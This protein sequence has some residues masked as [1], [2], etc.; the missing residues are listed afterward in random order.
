MVR[1]AQLL[2]NTGSPWNASKESSPC[3]WKGVRCSSDNSSVVQLS[4]SGFGISSSD[5]LL[6]I[7][8]VKSLQS[9]DLSNN[10]LSSIPDKFISDCGNIDGLKLLNFSKNSLVGVLPTFHG[11]VGLES[12]DLS[13]NSLSGNISLQLDG[14]VSLKSLNLCSN[15]FS[16]SV[17]VKLG[18]SMVL[19]QLVLSTNFLQSS[20]PPE[21]G[22]YQNLNLIDLSVNK[23][24]GSI[25]DTVGNLTK[26]ETFI[27]SLNNLTGIIPPS[28][29]S[30]RTLKRFAANQNQF[31]GTIP[32]GITSFVRILDL[33]YNKLR[34]SIPSD[35]LSHKQLLYVDLSYN[36]LDGPIP[37]DLSPSLFRLRLG[38][39]R[40]N[41][42]IPSSFATLKGLTYLELDNNSLT[43][44]I[45]G[46]LGSCQS[47]ALLNLAQNQLTG[48][49]PPALGN[50]TNLEVLKLQL[51]KLDGEIPEEIMKL[52]KL[53]ILN[54]SSNSLVGL[55]PSSFSNLQSLTRLNLQGNSLNGSIPNS[56]SR[57]NSLIDLQLGQNQLGG[58]IPQMPLKLLIALNLS[59]NLFEGTI[60]TTL[61]QLT[62]LEVL[63]LSNNKFLGE[64][65]SFLTE[66]YSLSQL[67]VS[68]NQLTGVIPEFRPYV[69]LQYSGGNLGL[70]NKTQG[71]SQGSPKK[72]NSVALAVIPAVVSAVLAVGIVT[73]L[74]FSFSR[75]FLKVDDQQSQPGED[76]PWPRIIE[77]NLLTSNAIHR[78]NIDFDKAMEIVADPINSELK[79]RFS[80]YYKTTMPYGANYFVKKL[81]W[82][83]KIYQSGNHDKF[84]QELE[85][86]GK[87]SN[88][89]VMTPLAYV[90]TVDSAYLFYEYAKKGT[91]FDVL[92]GKLGNDFD[93]ASRY[94]IAVGVA[95]ALT[96]LHGC[97]SGPILLLDLSSRNIFLK[98]LKEPVVGDIELYKVID[99]TK[100][101]GSLSTVAGS[102]GYIAPEYAYT[103][104]I[105]MAGNVYSFGIILLELLTGKPAVSEG[106]ELAKWVV[107]K[108]K[109]QDKLDHILDFNISRS[110][111][112]VRGQMLAVLQIALSCVSLSPVARPKMKSVLR[113]ILNAR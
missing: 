42:T 83:D 26:L 57:L 38:S 20:I 16:G 91:L 67:I 95:Q 35:L 75:R 18:N 106:T 55:I 59:S 64:I 1:V 80:T 66:L 98:S 108:A 71:T 107:N 19:E 29:V 24:F 48:F 85:V 25:P 87:L 88:S 112:S 49:L 86:I 22:N 74:V 9:L 82:S 79:T 70:V 102:V 50:L 34:G 4:L 100:S 65:P 78:S 15:K 113:M 21:I 14:L 51:N 111:A 12:L 99:P 63:D 69:T 2:N 37:A 60:P 94:S 61:S 3:S 52:S 45:P 8:E 31:D 103:M 68:N 10:Y 109:Q 30:I 7:C 11:F 40:L 5:F 28:L 41:G 33:S 46:E 13:F 90:L 81:N 105:T 92:H 17:P 44:G 54:I 36:L 84:G 97:A 101:T 47:L 56:I 62:N 73:I 93:W 43:S 58:S 6:A 89:N 27:L 110:S 23:L 96:F 104:R 77:M 39:N 76:V 72:R 32:N 53:S